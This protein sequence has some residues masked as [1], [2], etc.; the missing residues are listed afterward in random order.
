MT[1]KSPLYFYKANDFPGVKVNLS[2]KIKSLAK[3]CD[4][5]LESPYTKAKEKGLKSQ[6]KKIDLSHSES[7]EWLRR[8]IE[9]EEEE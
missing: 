1:N 9:E 6:K 2:G 4:L 5:T 3:S 7:Y 8:H